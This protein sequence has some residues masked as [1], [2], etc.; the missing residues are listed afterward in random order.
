MRDLPTLP[1]DG[2]TEEIVDTWIENFEDN[3][4]DQWI[5]PDTREME[6]IILQK[7]IGI[8]PNSFSSLSEEEFFTWD[9]ELYFKNPLVDVNSQMDDIHK[10]LISSNA[11]IYTSDFGYRYKKDPDGNIV[12]TPTRMEFYGPGIDS[13]TSPEIRNAM[14]ESLKILFSLTKEVGMVPIVPQKIELSSSAIYL[15]RYGNLSYDDADKV[16]ISQ[17]EVQGEQ[18]HW[19]GLTYESMA[20]TYRLMRNEDNKIFDNLGQITNGRWTIERPPELIDI[21]TEFDD[22]EEIGYALLARE[23][24]WSGQMSTSWDSLS[25]KVHADRMR[26]GYKEIEPGVWE[27][28]EGGKKKFHHWDSEDEETSKSFSSRE[29]IIERLERSSEGFKRALIRLLSGMTD[30]IEELHT[31]EHEFGR[32]F[33]SYENA[34]FLCANSF[35]RESEF[36]SEI[37]KLT[38]RLMIAKHPKQPIGNPDYWISTNNPERRLS[39]YFDRMYSMYRRN[40]LLLC[41]RIG[42]LEEA[43]LILSRDPIE[44]RDLAQ[45]CHSWD[46]NRNNY[47]NNKLGREIREVLGVSTRCLEC[48]KFMNN[49]LHDYCRKHKP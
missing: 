19:S 23:M 36:S 37:K 1:P 18:K 42:C 9:Y 30:R 26:S 32:E 4:W 12:W 43:A 35:E 8:C 2:S 38:L 40:L 17:H 22:F 31:G 14:I 3:Y 49:P 5:N 29:E 47:A 25:G 21:I 44:L 41:D 6:I 33:C 11:I 24:Y 46:Y 34:I 16:E 28:T 27:L 39:K 45:R 48:G 7:L 10:K 15:D 13:D 20:R